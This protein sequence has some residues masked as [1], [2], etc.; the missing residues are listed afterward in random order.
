MLKVCFIG[1][2]VVAVASHPVFGSGDDRASKEV[3]M[4][5]SYVSE[6]LIKKLEHC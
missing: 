6:I 4:L 5:G 3:C 1:G 2:V